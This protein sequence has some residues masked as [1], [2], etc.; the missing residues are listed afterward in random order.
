[1]R[2]HAPYLDMLKLSKRTSLPH[3]QTNSLGKFEE[4]ENYFPEF[5]KVEFWL[6]RCVS[7]THFTAADP[8]WVGWNTLHTIALYY[9]EY[10]DCEGFL[11]TSGPTDTTCTH[12]LDTKNSP[13]VTTTGCC[14][15]YRACQT[16]TTRRATN[17]WHLR[18]SYAT[19][20]IK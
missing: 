14:T 2:S 4:V 7:F 15:V 16:S 12:L 9:Y 1:M 8:A 19:P 18:V 6:R 13:W 17:W 5:F 10:I 11:R 3:P 20:S